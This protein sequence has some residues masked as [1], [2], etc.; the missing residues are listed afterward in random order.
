MKSSG[1][2]RNARPT[3]AS[4]SRVFGAVRE[5]L[6]TEFGKP[7]IDGHRRLGVVLARAGSV[8]AA[9]EAAVAGRSAIGV[10]ITP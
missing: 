6:V 10:T 3:I 8:E 5:R 4:E 1:T 7:A 9:R 2:R